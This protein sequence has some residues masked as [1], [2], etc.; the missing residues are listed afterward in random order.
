MIFPIRGAI[1]AIYVYKYKEGEP[2]KIEL[3]ANS[4]VNRQE[5][6]RKQMGDVNTKG[7]PKLSPGAPRSLTGKHVRAGHGR[8]RDGRDVEK[9]TML[10]CRATGK[11]TH[12]KGRQHNE[13][14]SMPDG[15][16]HKRQ[17]ERAKNLGHRK[18]DKETQH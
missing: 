12:G 11:N 15:R 17:D 8:E 5:G 4:T 18:T 6:S 7:D 10:Q 2:C 9:D 3:C 13:D 14:L 1:K 16:L